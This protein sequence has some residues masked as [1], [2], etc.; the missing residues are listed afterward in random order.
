VASYSRL[1]IRL[2]GALKL[3][4]IFINLF[5]ELS[6]FVTYDVG[7]VESG[8]VSLEANSVDVYDEHFAG[9]DYPV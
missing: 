7:A 9:S 4:T 3:V 1:D 8:T 5:L 6:W 2:Q